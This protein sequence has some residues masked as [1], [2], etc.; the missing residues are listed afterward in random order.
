MI[1][2]HLIGETISTNDNSANALM[3]QRHFGKKIED[4]I[5]FTPAEALFLV[6]ERKLEI[7]QKNKKL[8]KKEVQEKFKKLDKKFLIKYI[9]FKDLRKKGHIVKT[10]LK[11]GADFRVYEKGKPN[12]HAKWVLFVE[13]ESQKNSWHDFAAKNRVA[14]STKKNL[15]ITLVDEEQDVTYYEVSWIKP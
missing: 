11:F 2:A 5:H 12:S 8:S 6:E 10:G 13:H 9:V 4:K 7:L 1:Q 15:L 3:K 14:H